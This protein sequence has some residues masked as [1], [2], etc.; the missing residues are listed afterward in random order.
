M[1]EVIMITGNNGKLKIAKEIFSKYNIKLLQHKMDTPEI[2][3]H[4]VEDVSKY[5]AE[6]ACNLL[7]KPVIKSDVGYYIEELNGFP[8]PF[9]RYINDMLSSEDILKLMKGKK[10]RTIYLKESLTYK[11]PKGEIKQFTNIEKATIS[12]EAMGEGS[13]FD[14]I[15]IFENSKYPKSMNTKQEN[16]EHF[17]KTLKIYEEMAKYIEELKE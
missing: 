6:Y 7:N 2:Q 4:N 15:V 9:L 12:E 11:N 10:N 5:S 1:K 16:H 17:V 3:S 8:G 13:T 14:K